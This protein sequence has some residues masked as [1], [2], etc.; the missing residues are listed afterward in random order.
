MPDAAATRLPGATFS[1]RTGSA[2]LTQLT[3]RR[4]CAGVAHTDPA[5]R[6]PRCTRLPID[7]ANRRAL[8]AARPRLSDSET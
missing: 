4:D 5:G 6:P 8:F 2:F 3:R 1:R 7:Y